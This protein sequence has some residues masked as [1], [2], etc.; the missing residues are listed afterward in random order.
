MGYAQLAKYFVTFMQFF[1]S[2]VMQVTANLSPNQVTPQELPHLSEGTI[3]RCPGCPVE[4]RGQ[5]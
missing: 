5:V 2:R 3:P 1:A 4:S